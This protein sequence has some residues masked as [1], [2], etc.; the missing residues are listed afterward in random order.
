ML[1]LVLN[2]GSSS[3]KADIIHGETGHREYKLR[4]ERLPEAPVITL[5]GKP[6]PFA[7][8]GFD[9]ALLAGLNELRQSLGGVELSGVGHRVVH[10]GEK[11]SQ[12]VII[13]EQVEQAIDQLSSLAPIHNPINLKGIR[14]ARQVFP[15]CLMWRFLTLPST[16]PCR[17]V[18]RL[19]P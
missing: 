12:P 1:I 14:L 6:V 8:K 17:H 15:R 9:G 5:N 2:T 10:G 13:D 4:I 16:V 7:G 11:Y 19:M 3:I 18:P